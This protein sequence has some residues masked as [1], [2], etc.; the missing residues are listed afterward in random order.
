MD[1]WFSCSVMEDW[2]ENGFLLPGKMRCWL[3]SVVQLTFNKEKTLSFDDGVTVKFN[4]F[5]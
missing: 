2:F 1:Y 4:L 3:Q 5:S